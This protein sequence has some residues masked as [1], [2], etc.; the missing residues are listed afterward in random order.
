[1]D[2]MQHEPGSDAADAFGGRHAQA[3]PTLTAEEIMRLTRFGATQTF[4]TGDALYRAGE[5]GHGLVILQRA[6]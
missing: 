5:T 2:E 6:A 1:M 3:F 4:G